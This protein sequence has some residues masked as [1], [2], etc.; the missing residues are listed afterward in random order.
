MRTAVA[1]GMALL[2]L[3][4][5]AVQARICTPRQAEAADAMVDRLDSWSR[6]AQM[7]TRYGHCDD[8]AIAEGNSEAIARLLVDHWASLPQLVSLIRRDSA[9]QPFVLRHLDGSLAD[10][11]LFKIKQL[12][13]TACPAGATA[14]CAELAA[15]AAAG[16]TDQQ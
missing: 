1:A 13:Q 6:V 14:L 4:P 3:L 15:T 12:A 8:G 10:A 5:A 2:L 7:R 16:L 11:D 9:L